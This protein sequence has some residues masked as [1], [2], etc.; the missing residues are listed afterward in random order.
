MNLAP[1]MVVTGALLVGGVAPPAHADESTDLGSIPT[2]VDPQITDAVTMPNVTVLGDSP[3]MAMGNLYVA[4]GQSLGIAYNSAPN[5]VISSI[6]LT[7]VQINSLMAPP[8]R[9]RSVDDT[10]EAK[11]AATAK[12]IRTCGDG[13]VVNIHVHVEPT[14][15][16]SPADPHT[17]AEVADTLIDEF[18]KELGEP[19][20][21]LGWIIPD[22][23][24]G[25]EDAGRVRASVLGSVH[26]AHVTSVDIHLHRRLH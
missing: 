1:I 5:S 13:C 9:T 16:S 18:A 10:T 7:A 26:D 24:D 17:P 14:R 2:V 21:A 4:T 3:A 15:D 19:I 6:T 23:D 22:G 20:D 8:V 25:I 11:I 12:R